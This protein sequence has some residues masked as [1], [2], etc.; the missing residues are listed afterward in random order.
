MK[1]KMQV[2]FRILSTTDSLAPLILK[3]W[4]S[5]KCKSCV[6]NVYKYKSI[7]GYRLGSSRKKERVGEGERQERG[8]ERRK[9]KEKGRGMEGRR[10]E[11]REGGKERDVGVNATK[12]AISYLESLLWTWAVNFCPHLI[13]PVLWDLLADAHPEC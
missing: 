10:T 12:R 13:P 3:T 9:E 6:L 11:G 1:N 7:L 5:L 2:L 4:V 8:K